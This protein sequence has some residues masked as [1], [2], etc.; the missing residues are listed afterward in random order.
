MRGRIGVVLSKGKRPRNIEA[1][2]PSARHD[3]GSAGLHGKTAPLT[4]T[5]ESTIKPRANGSDISA[6]RPI[7]SKGE[8]R[9]H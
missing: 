9:S 2:D 1:L 3:N 7:G 5:R 6:L 8:M 4:A